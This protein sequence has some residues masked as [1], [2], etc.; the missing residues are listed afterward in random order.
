MKPYTT[1]PS[2]A[3]VLTAATLAL[4]SATMADADW[5]YTTWGSSPEAVVAA[6]N[7][8]ATANPNRDKDSSPNRA[9]LTAPY[10]GLGFAFD[11]YF[12]FDAANRLVFVDLEPRN[13]SD[14][15]EIRFGLT[16]TY[17]KP[18]ETGSFGLIKWWNRDTRNGVVYYEIETCYLRY[19]PY[20]EPNAEGGL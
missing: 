16:S 6:S 15:R 5:Q 19:M 8:V 1:L 3:S 13:P 4:A 17:G 11:A 7:G 12:Q 14:C 20:V 10:E 9:L 18:D 2:L